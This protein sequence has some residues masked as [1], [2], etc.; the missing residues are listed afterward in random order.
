M[1]DVIMTMRERFVER[2]MARIG[3]PYIWGDT[4]CSGIVEK[5]FNEIG[6]PLGDVSAAHLYDRFHNN[7]VMRTAAKIGSLYLYSNNMH[8]LAISHVMTLIKVWGNGT[9]ILAGARGGDSKVR[10]EKDAAERGAFVDVVLDSYWRT[11]LVMVV[12]PFIENN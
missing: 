12:D 4:D 10:T 5:A 6:I 8:E 7:K 11:N 2:I 3:E 9:R 1:S